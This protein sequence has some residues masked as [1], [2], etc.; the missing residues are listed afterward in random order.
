M[1]TLRTKQKKPASKYLHSPYMSYK[2][3]NLPIIKVHGL[4]VVNGRIHSGEENRKQN[5][6]K[7]KYIKPAE[8]P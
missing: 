7:I 5:P 4:K 6:N 8:W 2:K 3:Y 1:N